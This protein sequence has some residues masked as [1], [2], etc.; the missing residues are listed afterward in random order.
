MVVKK[1][2]FKLLLTFAVFILAGLLLAGC[3]GHKEAAT[4]ISENNPDKSNTI[5][6]RDYFGREVEVP[7]QAKKLGC[8]YA[9][10]GHVVAML[11]KGEN[12]V[13][14]VEGLKRDVLMTGM[15]PNIKDASVPT[16]GGGA[17]NL[18]ELIRVNPDVI[19]IKG[20]T[21][22]NEGEIE[23]LEKSKIPYL[24]VDYK[25]IKEQQYIIE[26]IGQVVG[27]QDKAKRYNQFYRQ[28]IDRVQKKVAGIPLKERIRVY[29]SVNEA[30]RTDPK[31]SLPADWLQ[32]A[33]AV[34]V[35]VDKDLKLIEEKYFA[36]LEQILVWDPEVIIVNQTGVA[37]YIM[38]N[39]QW[40]SLSA[41]K[42]HKVYQMPNGLSRWGHP[43]S[44]ETP[45]AILWTAKTLYPE[46]FS[47]LDMVKETKIFYKEFYNFDL[48]DETAKKIL[49]GEGMRL[50]KGE[51]NKK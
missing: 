44:L 20:D 22:T 31:D 46:L 34:D 26:M 41:V 23:K 25:N 38:K 27:C 24:V 45:M 42:N 14:V 28:C 10:S 8:L 7:A 37:D 15:L 48:S 4:E 2:F 9:F 3:S 51:E 43:G 35:S 30:T 5:T 47:D 17:V 40:A 39:K 6:V 16:L 12:I 29:H 18:E 50:S 1:K 32:V 49:S 21:A 36:S 33:G 13:A 19:F 11:G